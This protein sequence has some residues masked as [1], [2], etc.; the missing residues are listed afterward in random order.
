MRHLRR[1]LLRIIGRIGILAPRRSALWPRAR[2][3]LVIK[4]DHLGDLLL[5]TPALGELR[6]MLPDAHITLMIGPWSAAAI[7]GS[8]LV[9]AVRFCPF[10]GFTRQPKPG[11]FQPYILLLR[12]A[13]LL[14]LGRYDVALIA[15]DDHWWGALLALAAGIPRR[16]G[17]GMPDVAPLLTD[18]LPYDPTMHVTQQA[19]GLVAHL[20]GAAPDSPAL[21]SAPATHE[22]ER[23]AEN[24]LA[25]HGCDAG[26]YLVAI[27]PGAGGAAKL[28]PAT[29]WIMIV[30]EMVARGWRVVLTG[31]PAERQL[32]ATIARGLTRPP[33]LLV[34][35]TSLGQLAAL[36]RRCRL[37]VGVDSG[38]LHLATA[39]GARTVALFGPGDHRRFGPWGPPE[40]HCVVRSGL[41][42]SPCGMLDA[43]PRGTRPSECMT[44]IS[45][46]QVLASVEALIP[47]DGTAAA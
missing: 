3:V 36:Y 5:L 32:V 45:V 37:V 23:W 31:G 21:M 16:I 43:C 47:R 14:R 42:C 2:R 18:V 26:G 44:T 25:A 13:L 7:R 34:G 30:D 15:R 27:H 10:P 38:P 17:Y 12:T 11:L 29:R 1:L 46:A 39:A 28:W 9:D 4:P 35:E 19:R 41:W 40:H 6:T 24:W 33:L 8:A 22:D 20:V